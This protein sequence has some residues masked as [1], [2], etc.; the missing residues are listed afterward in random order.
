MALTIVRAAA[1]TNE[2]NAAAEK[3]QSFRNV[4][5]CTYCKY[6]HWDE[7]ALKF[8]EEMHKEYCEE[9]RL[10]YKSTSNIK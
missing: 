10:N 8:H 7:F 6:Q 1:N 2:K 9:K 5:K 3:E 4:R